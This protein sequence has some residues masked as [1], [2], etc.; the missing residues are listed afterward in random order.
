MSLCDPPTS[1]AYP[2]PP[3]NTAHLRV[4]FSPPDAPTETTPSGGRQSQL[5]YRFDRIDPD[6]LFILARILDYGA[7]KYDDPDGS[8]W[9]LITTADHLNHALT[10]IY[11]YLS[12]DRADDHL[13]HAFCRLMMA[14]GVALRTGY[15]AR[16]PDEKGPQP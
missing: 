2:G 8:N 12:A 14:L 6:A 10:H 9:K 4:K 15:D 16:Q 1:S 3:T 11:A 13:G 5:S 7:R